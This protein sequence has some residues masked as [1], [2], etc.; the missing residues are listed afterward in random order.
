MRHLVNSFW[1][2]EYFPS[3]TWHPDN[4]LLVVDIG[5]FSFFSIDLEQTLFLYSCW[6]YF[7]MILFFCC[8]S[9]FNFAIVLYAFAWFFCTS[10]RLHK[11]LSVFEVIVLDWISGLGCNSCWLTV[12]HLMLSTFHILRFFFCCMRCCRADISLMSFREPV[13]LWCSYLSCSAHLY[14]TST[15]GVDFFLSHH[16]CCHS[17]ADKAVIIKRL[18]IGHTWH[19]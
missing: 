15:S 4:C 6:Q 7:C 3:F 10:W 16:R 8:R 17:F 13:C 18:R 9:S 12:C 5:V 14:F 1:L 19:L 2:N 11:F